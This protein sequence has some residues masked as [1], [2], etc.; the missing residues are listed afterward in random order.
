MVV[1]KLEKALTSQDWPVFVKTHAQL[2]NTYRYQDTF[3]HRFEE[4]TDAP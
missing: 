1:R 3:A 4:M 2:S